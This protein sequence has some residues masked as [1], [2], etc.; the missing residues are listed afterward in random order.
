MLNEDAYRKAREEAERLP[1]PF[2]KAILARCCQCSLCAKRNIAEREVASCSDRTAQSACQVLLDLLLDKALFALKHA[3]SEIPHAKAMKIQCGG[4]AGIAE[5]C[6]SS[7]DDVHAL[8]LRALEK[9]GSLDDLPYS[10]IMKS[11]AAFEI[12]KRHQ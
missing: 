2:G 10:G 6:G 1:C 3:Q 12:R 8:V 9:F 4:L 7:Q 5:A 11:I